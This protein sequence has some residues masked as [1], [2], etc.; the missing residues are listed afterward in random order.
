MGKRMIEI[1]APAGSFESMV[2]AIN[3]GKC[4]IQ[5]GEERHGENGDYVTTVWVDLD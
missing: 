3:A 1:L 5:K 4:G 2:A